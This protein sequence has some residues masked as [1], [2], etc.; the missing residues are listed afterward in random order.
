MAKTD[1]SSKRLKMRRI[2]E[3]FCAQRTFYSSPLP[4]A[5]ALFRL[6]HRVCCIDL[7]GRGFHRGRRLFS[8]LLSSR[9]VRLL[10]VLSL[11]PAACAEGKNA[12][13]GRAAGAAGRLLPFERACAVVAI[14]HAD[15][16]HYGH[17]DAHHIGHQHALAH[18]HGCLEHHIGHQHALAHVCL[19]HPDSDADAFP[20]VHVVWPG[21]LGRGQ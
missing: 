13:P 10:C 11:P 6:V 8:F 5:A 4:P 21:D 14:A 20:E 1:T 16:Q 3:L 9:S 18:A 12:A 7:P 17:Q 19:E 15:A 2:G